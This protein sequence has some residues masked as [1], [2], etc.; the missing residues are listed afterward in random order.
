MEVLSGNAVR[1]NLPLKWKIHKVFH[2]SML[3][4]FVQGNRDV[5]LENVLGA[6]DPMEADDEN[7][8]EDVMSSME[9]RGK[10]SHLVKRRGVPA[11]K[12]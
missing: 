8:L 6:S 9:S 2:I 12:N 11:K 4:P 5:N 3:E 10:V 1:L 7:Q